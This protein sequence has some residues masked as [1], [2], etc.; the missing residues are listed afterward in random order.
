MTA[1]AAV[2]FDVVDTLISRDRLRPR[3]E[4]A[5]AGEGALELWFARLLRDAF[6]ITAAGGY[7]PFR[8]VAAASLTGLLDN[9]SGEAVETV[10]AGFKDLDAHPDA[11]PAMQRLHQAGVRILT[12]TNGSPETTETLL[13][14]NGLARLIERS[15]SVEEAKVWKPAPEPYLHAAR[16]ADVEPHE[17]ALVTVHGWDVHG[18]KQAGLRGGWASR[19][20]GQFPASL[21]APD[22]WG[23][24]LVEVVEGLM[25]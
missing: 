18:A 11:E 13:E 21:G 22:V 8:E 12:L 7:R 5:G 23:T 6:A 9:P 2:A 1:P 16:I 17:V 15:I 24:D 19:L 14:R 4:Q 20:E 3:L 25:R 10:L